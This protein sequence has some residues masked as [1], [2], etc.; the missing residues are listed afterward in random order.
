M[1]LH[2]LSLRSRWTDASHR[3]YCARLRVMSVEHEVKLQAEPAERREAC[4]LQLLVGRPLRW[5]TMAT[6]H[7][8]SMP[9]NASHMATSTFSGL[10]LPEP[11]PI[12]GDDDREKASVLNDPHGRSHGVLNGLH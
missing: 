5:R 12:R 3:V 10:R 1:L 6:L 4:Q 7:G 8:T 9:S 2:P 11:A